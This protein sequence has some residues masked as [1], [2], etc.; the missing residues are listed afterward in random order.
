VQRRRLRRSG[1][2]AGTDRFFVGLLTV[3]PLLTMAPDARRDDIGNNWLLTDPPER[4]VLIE[5]VYVSANGTGPRSAVRRLE[6]RRAVDAA[7]PTS[8]SR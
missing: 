5:D 2:G 7:A 4:G 8:R 3:L 1:P 6:H